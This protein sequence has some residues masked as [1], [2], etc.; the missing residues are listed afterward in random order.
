MGFLGLGFN[1]KEEATDFNMALSEWERMKHQRAEIAKKP[2]YKDT[3]EFALDSRG[4]LFIDDKF[5]KKTS[6]KKPSTFNGDFSLAGPPS[7]KKSEAASN[8]IGP[9]KASQNKVKKKKKK[10][11]EEKGTEDSLFDDFGDFGNFQ[12]ADVNVNTGDAFDP[13]A[14]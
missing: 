10:K 6:S 11:K 3:G 14:E 2:A 5:S 7:K 13:F 1:K 8:L 4:K 9:P 12:S